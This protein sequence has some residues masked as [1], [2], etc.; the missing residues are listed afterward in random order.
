L[1]KEIAMQFL[2]F[3]LNTLVAS[4]AT[5]VAPPL[6]R[7]ESV[8][9]RAVIDGDT[10]DVT[11]FGRVQLLGVN[12]APR[13]ANAAREKLSGLVLQRWVRLEYD[14]EKTD[15][16]RRRAAY[17]ITGDGVCVNAVLVREGLARVTAHPP[18]ARFDELKDA[19]GEAQ[20]LEK[21]IWSGASGESPGYTRRPAPR[22]KVPKT[23]KSPKTSIKQEQRRSSWPISPSS[24]H[25]SA[26][27]ANATS[28]I[29]GSITGRSGFL[30]S[31]SP[32]AR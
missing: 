27:F 4:A 15:G 16:R 17:V 19:E 28:S 9:V 18:L 2:L 32:P 25:R 3:V 31:S 23:S 10:I 20:R 8:L 22:Q 14:G 1:S 6:E 29:T 13:F 7:S 21:G 5:F 12:V 24:T 26:R 11:Q 30:F